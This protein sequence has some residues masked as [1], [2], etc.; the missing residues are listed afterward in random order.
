[1]KIQT[2]EIFNNWD[3]WIT[4]KEIM[5]YDVWVLLHN[6]KHELSSL[7]R[8]NELISYLVDGK[9]IT[10]PASEIESIE[11]RLDTEDQDTF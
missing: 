3:Y 7:N 6:A 5:K 4:K 11:V 2:K 1:M 8:Q 9:I 10:V